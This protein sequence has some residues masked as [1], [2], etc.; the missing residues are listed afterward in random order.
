MNN[1]LNILEQICIEDQYN[2]AQTKEFIIKDIVNS[3]FDNKQKKAIEALQA[4]FNGKYYQ[5]KEKRISEL[6]GQSRFEFEVLRDTFLLNEIL[7]LTIPCDRPVK[8]QAI[9]GHLAPILEMENHWDAIKTA[10]ELISVVGSATDFYDILLV[11]HSGEKS[12]EVQSNYKLEFDTLVKLEKMKYLPPLIT[13]PKEIKSNLDTPYLSKNVVQKSV[14]LGKENHH[15]Y[16]QALDVINIANSVALE[17]DTDILQYEETSKKPLDTKEKLLNFQLLR[18]SS[19]EVFE[20]MINAGNKFYFSW[21][22]DKRGR[23]YSMGY[24]INIQAN[25]Y[26]KAM[27]SLA[28]KEIIKLD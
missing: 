12:I 26:R 4:Y 23:M 20:D 13:K 1:M 9:V 28:K 8:I 22:F 14:I 10:A 21:R 19:K 17:L 24:H 18:E 25:E 3:D 7:L 5:S 15:N 6:T 11:E 16:P 2:K 27:L